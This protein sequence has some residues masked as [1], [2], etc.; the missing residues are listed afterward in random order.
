MTTTMKEPVQAVASFQSLSLLN[1]CCT[2]LTHIVEGW[3]GN[4]RQMQ[5]RK[6]LFVIPSQSCKV[7]CTRG[8]PAGQR[9]KGR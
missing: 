4:T 5:R 9:E 1:V 6:D 7:K 3:L 8:K 2:L